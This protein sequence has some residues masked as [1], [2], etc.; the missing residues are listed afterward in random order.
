[1]NYQKYVEIAKEL[2]RDYA[3]KI[4]LAIIL[5]VI[6][7]WLIR[8]FT[9]YSIRIMNKK[10]VDNSLQSFLSSLLSI[11]LKVLLVITLLTQVGIGTTSFLA[12]LGAAG[13]AIGLALQG[14]LSNFAGG[15]L[16]LFFKPFKVGDLIKAQGEL[17]QVKEIH[18][19]VTKLAVAGGKTAIIPNG[20][21][22]NGN[23]VNYN[24]GDKVGVPINI[25]VSYD[26]NIKEAR[27]VIL[28]VMN[29]HQDIFDS[30]VPTVNVKELADSSVN[31]LVIPWT[32]PEKYWR[33]YFDV[34]ENAKEALD[35]AGITIPFPQ[36]DV[37]LFKHEE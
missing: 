17:G 15:A 33:V 22:A 13:L 20:V 2:V 1:M 8:I 7:L 31:L 11:T 18:I 3:P 5:L 30:P 36:T 35:Q 28:K 12:V 24:Q 34:L 14:S 37:H 10:G 26:S 16:I 21:L 25:G 29:A 23:I 19:L 6:G 32:T 27:Q 9:N 4:I